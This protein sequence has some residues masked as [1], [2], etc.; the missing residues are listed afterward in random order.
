ML[1]HTILYFSSK[2]NSNPFCSCKIGTGRLTLGGLLGG[3]VLGRVWGTMGLG[4][5][6]YFEYIVTYN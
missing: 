1:F 3:V 2:N 5:L 6:S 4:G